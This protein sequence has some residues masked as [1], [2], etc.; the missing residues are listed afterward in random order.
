VSLGRVWLEDESSGAVADVEVEAVE[1]F[2][3]EFVGF[4]RRAYQS[5]CP[6]LA[7]SVRGRALTKAP[8]RSRPVRYSST[9][10]I[11]AQRE[12][13]EVLGPIPAESCS[14]GHLSVIVHK[15]AHR[16]STGRREHALPL[17]D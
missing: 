4:Y 13:D 1:G 11:V 6:S 14:G 8:A 3:S 9:A 16:D 17:R 2:S 15:E 10:R 12:G 7:G 5:P